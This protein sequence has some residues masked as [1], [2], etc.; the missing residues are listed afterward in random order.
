MSYPDEGNIGMDKR[1]ACY[2]KDGHEV[3]V[4]SAFAG[5]ATVRERIK[6]YILEMKQNRI[7]AGEGILGCCD[8]DDMSIAAPEENF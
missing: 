5:S 1:Y 8:R 3:M 4:A 2:E 7:Y 6:A